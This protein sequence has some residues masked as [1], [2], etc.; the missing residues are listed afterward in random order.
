MSTSLRSATAGPTRVPFDGDG[1][2][3]GAAHE[4]AAFEAR[5]VAPD[6]LGGDGEQFGEFTHLDPTVGARLLEDGL[7]AFR[8]VHA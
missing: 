4:A 8:C 6:G 2:A 7:V 5:E 3:V 1:A